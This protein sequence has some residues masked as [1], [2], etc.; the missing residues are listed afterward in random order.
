MAA[1][2]KLISAPCID[3]TGAASAEGVISSVSRAS[4]VGRGSAKYVVPIVDMV[5][6]AGSLEYWWK[7]WIRLVNIHPH[8]HY[9][10]CQYDQVDIGDN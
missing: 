9:H 3:F 4:I 1:S 2:V 8:C 5:K 6:A 7:Y 10:Q